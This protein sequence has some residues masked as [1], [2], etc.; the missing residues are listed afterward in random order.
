MSISILGI[1]TIY[2]VVFPSCKGKEEALLT[3]LHQR[4]KIPEAEINAWKQSVLD[5]QKKDKKKKKKPGDDDGKNENDDKDKPNKQEG[6]WTPLPPLPHG[7]P[8]E[9]LMERI[10]AVITQYEFPIEKQQEHLR[11]LPK[12]VKKRYENREKDLLEKLHNQYRVPQNTNINPW[13]NSIGLPSVQLPEDANPPELTPPPID[14][15]LWDG[16]PDDGGSQQKPKSTKMTPQSEFD[17]NMLQLLIPLVKSMTETAIKTAMGSNDSSHDPPPPLP[18]AES[19]N[20]SYNDNDNN[21]NN[22]DNNTLLGLNN[23]DKPTKQT[24]AT[25][26]TRT[27]KRRPPITATWKRTES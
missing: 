2:L 19:N 10:E 5:Q 27:T 24:T 14:P 25:T 6:P 9:K 11:Q 23:T 17:R 8:R 18:S 26:H 22:T 7:I 4:Y 3:N 12:L 16:S 15:N 13:L 20:A 1:A 21:N